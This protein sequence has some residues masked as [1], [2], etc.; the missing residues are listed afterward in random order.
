MKPGQCLVI[1][2]G[3]A[4]EP[5]P[6]LDD[7]TPLSVARGACLAA[8]AAQGRLGAL[9]GA[10]APPW[11]SGLRALCGWQGLPL[12]APADLAYGPLV[13]A[14]LGWELPTRAYYYAGQ[15]VT[16]D[17]DILRDGRLEDLS[18]VETE[19]LAAT[20][21]PALAAEGV[22]LDVRGGG[23]RMLVG[24]RG[25]REAAPG[26]PPPRWLEGES[27]TALNEA[28]EREDWPR[29][30]FE[31]TRAAWAEH[32]VNMVRLDLGLNPAHAL[33]VW[34][35]G[36][37]V[38]R[39][40][41]AS[42]GALLV[43][44]EPAV[45]GWGLAQGFEIQSLPPLSALKKGVPWFRLRAFVTALRQVERVICYLG[46]P[47][48]LGNFGSAVEKIRVLEQWDRVMLAPLADILAAEGLGRLVVLAGG[49]VSSRTGRP[50]AA[51]CPLVVCQP[52]LAARVQETA[53]PWDEAAGRTGG[54]GR[55]RPA[56]LADLTR[57][58]RA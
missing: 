20:V 54:L 3:A 8:L 31:I 14:G 57:A 10:D 56:D 12:P 30:L 34:G 11:V 50:C 24:L 44:N 26:G 19:A 22:D 42:V 23:G 47:G 33:W 37:P 6:E 9:V 13:A 58:D 15:A 40:E 25:G 39:R 43:S 53:V 2:E 36:P 29:R 32:P 1:Y 17:E 28:D 21:R 41:A 51:D 55:L 46:A 7:R 18:A 35:G 27:S 38:A 52:A 4:D 45:R 5:L 49:A 48:E 16:L